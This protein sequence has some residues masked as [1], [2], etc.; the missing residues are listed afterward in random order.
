MAEEEGPPDPSSFGVYYARLL[1]QQNMLQ[2]AARTDTYRQAMMCNEADFDGR[3][4]LD[5]GAGTGILAF[6]A[7]Q[8]GAARVYAVEASRM[9]DKAARLVSAVGNAH[10]ARTAE[11]DEA[12]AY[13]ERVGAPYGARVDALDPNFRIHV[14]RARVEDAELPE[15][16]DVIVSEPLGFLLVHE[17]ML[18]A[19]VT[20]RDR[21]LAPG[22][23][24]FPTTAV[25]KALPVTDP[26]LWNEQH[27]KASF[28]RSEVFYG[29]DLTALY[30]DALEEYFSQAV[31]GHFNMDNAVADVPSTKAFDFSTITLRDLREFDVPL[32]FLATKTAIV[33]GLG[34][35]F[36]AAFHGTSRLVTLSTGPAAPGT[37][38]Y[39]CRLLLKHPIA[40]NANQ[41]VVG[42][43]HFKSNDRLS[44]DLTL[45]LHLAGT[46]ISSSQRIRLDDQMYH[47]LQTPPSHHNVI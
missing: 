11:A 41:R 38:W 40:V 16:V 12:G 39:Q 42:N 30:E 22:G 15:R 37:H 32:D 9:A 3:V 29:V 45:Q 28:W 34:C 24:M 5:V 20:A 7:A 6:F 33:H 8:A 26:A 27:A 25:L 36:D 35:W 31:V 47:Y 21:F 44:Y 43:I 18:E 23:T 13:E 14:V 1:H 46:D 2:D 10:L 19:F 17:R 4:V